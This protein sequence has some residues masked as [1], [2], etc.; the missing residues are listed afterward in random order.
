MQTRVAEISTILREKIENFQPNAQI[1]ET[2]RVLAI[3]DGIARIYGLDKVQAG[4]W[5]DIISTKTK[6]VVRAIATNLEVDNVGAV[7]VG[8]DRLVEEGDLV[9][10]TNKI[11]DVNVGMGLL[12]RVVDGLGNPIDGKGALHDVYFAPVERKAPGIIAP[13]GRDQREW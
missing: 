1:A 7:I 8:N 13:R 11:I 3:G 4:E 5:I 12:G 2:G 10:R 6:E 9:K